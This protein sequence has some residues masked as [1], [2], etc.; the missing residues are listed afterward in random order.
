[1]TN[2]IKTA[3]QWLHD[4]DA[5]LITASNGF[6]ISEGLNL[7]ASDRKLT[8]VLGNLV[9][10]YN[11]PNLLG[12]LNY[13]YPNVLDKWRVYARIAEYY[14]YNY[15]PAELM[16]KLRQIVGDKPYFI[17]TSNIDHHFALAG[18][19]N[20]LEVE[21]NWQTGICTAHPKEHPAVDLKA[22]LHEI[23]EKD[24][25][26]NLIE[27]DLPTCSSCG[28]PLATNLPGPTFNM[29]QVQVSAFESFI[30]RYQTKKI[31][32]LELGIGPQN[33][34]IKAPSMQLVAGNQQSR[35]ITINKGQLNILAAIAD[36][37][38][39]F[40]STI[41]AAF[42]ALITGK[43]DVATQGPAKSAPQLSPEE[44]KRQQ[45]VLQSFYPSYTV[46][47]GYQP[48]ELIMYTTI[49]GKHPSHIHT[50]QYGRALMYSYGDPVDVHCFT[51]D[52]HYHLVKLGLNKEN[53]E[54]HGFY[55][56]PN[57][58]IAMED[59][60]G[61]TGFSQIRITLPSSASSELMIPRVEQLKK[62][63]PQQKEL[64]E[65]LT[66]SD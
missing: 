63:F 43:G 55:V 14:N 48:G 49:D 66:V 32:V 44:K 8:T 23:Y 26:G 3:Q 19:N 64:I 45:K 11:L 27:G 10:K 58:F 52:G 33:Q 47:K 41:L 4:A 29:D 46:N 24:Q 12:A 50:V 21:E 61:A 22:T 62:V 39:G 9:E 54:V 57:T 38:I 13:H 16:D 59:A 18:F 51:Q 36:R 40:S 31:L 35:Y 25:A 5:F 17:W 30:S 42:D 1:M 7:F 20:L 37:S 15:Y 53:N 6:S 60:K 28:E 34:M 2:A 56:E 65:R